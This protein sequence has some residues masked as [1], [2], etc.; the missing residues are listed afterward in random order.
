[1]NQESMSSLVPVSNPKT[2]MYALMERASQ[3][4]V[5]GDITLEQMIDLR[6]SICSWVGVPEGVLAEELKA[7][8]EWAMQRALKSGH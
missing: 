6:D 7:K 3:R 1:M 4:V 8:H 5:F 2:G